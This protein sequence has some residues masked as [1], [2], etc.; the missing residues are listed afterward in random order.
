VPE[1]RHRGVFRIRFSDA[2]FSKDQ[3]RLQ[4]EF[5]NRDASEEYLHKGFET[6]AH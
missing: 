2:L 1:Y 4:R 5:L 6:S 3:G